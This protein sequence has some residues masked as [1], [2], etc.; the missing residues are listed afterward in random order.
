[1]SK[2]RIGDEVKVIA[3]T[4][5]TYGVTGI[6]N[7]INE[8]NVRVDSS[9]FR[10]Y[11]KDSELELL[12][13]T[14]LKR[15]DRVFQRTY[16]KGTI[17]AIDI[18]NVCLVEFDKDSRYLTKKGNKKNL[19]WFFMSSL[20]FVDEPPV[21][22]HNTF[23]IGD[24]V[25]AVLDKGIKKARIVDMYSE[26]CDIM[27]EGGSIFNNVKYSNILT[28]TQ[29]EE[30][31]MKKT[32]KPNLIDLRNKFNTGDIVLIKNKRA[33]IMSKHSTYCNVLIEGE[34]EE[35]GFGY[36]EIQHISDQIP[37]AR[38][39]TLSAECA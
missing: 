2:F 32:T 26:T 9:F 37:P 20:T 33:R 34:T 8:E 11:Y 13:R 3:P 39:K 7:K 6:V 18:S 27:L 35:Q 16:G 12:H 38:Q 23:C 21:T 22:F 15:G 17:L 28:K 36:H 24:I 5:K 29:F 19:R 25:Y 4:F 30:R 14:E 31:L 1:M 10:G